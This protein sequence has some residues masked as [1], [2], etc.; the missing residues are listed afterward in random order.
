MGMV[1]RFAKKKAKEEAKAEAA[2]LLEEVRDEFFRKM[3]GLWLY[4]LHDKRGYGKKKLEQTY[5]DVIETYIKITA[6]YNGML[7]DDDMEWF[8]MEKHLRDIGVDLKE[9]QA[10]ADRR[11]PEGAKAVVRKERNNAENI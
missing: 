1:S 9:L 5:W 4:T 10:E 6:K 8:A 11:Y 2:R 3:E 7:D